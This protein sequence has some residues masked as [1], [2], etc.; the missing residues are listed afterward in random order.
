MLFEHI[1]K[2][3]KGLICGY[4]FFYTLAALTTIYALQFPKYFYEYNPIT[5][6]LFSQIGMI[7]TLLAVGFVTIVAMTIIPYLFRQSEY[8]GI[9]LNSIIVLVI[10]L[11]SGNNIYHL[12]NIQFLWFCDQGMNLLYMV[13]YGL[14]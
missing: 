6:T 2:V 9:F 13:R 11:D 8:T 14:V 10:G 3:H 4:A 7:P 12:T 1:T 5:A